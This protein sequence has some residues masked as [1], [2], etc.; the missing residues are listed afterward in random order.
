MHVP[1]RGLLGD[2]QARNHVLGR[3]ARLLLRESRHSLRITGVSQPN[4]SRQGPP[5]QHRTSLHGSPTATGVVQWHCQLAKLVYEK[6][7]RLPSRDSWR[8][9]IETLR[10]LSSLKSPRVRGEH[11]IDEHSIKDDG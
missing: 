1:E 5:R 8:E 3:G 2:Y 10:R 9:E 6:N 7:V 4:W 11:K